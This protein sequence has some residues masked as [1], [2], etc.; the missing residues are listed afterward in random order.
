MRRAHWTCPSDDSRRS[1]DP[2]KV[3]ARL[4]LKTPFLFHSRFISVFFVFKVLE[5]VLWVKK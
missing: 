2:V 1:S 5:R 4:S 3:V